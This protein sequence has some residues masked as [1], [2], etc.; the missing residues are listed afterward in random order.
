VSGDDDQTTTV[1]RRGSLAAIFAAV[2]ECVTRHRAVRQRR[3]LLA[4]L[5]EIRAALLPATA[6]PKTAVES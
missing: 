4:A 5:A 6:T 2:E 3:E 1:V